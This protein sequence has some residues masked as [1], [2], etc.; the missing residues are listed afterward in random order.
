MMAD[1]QGKIDLI[2]NHSIEEPNES[3]NHF[4]LNLPFNF[5]F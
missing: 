1:L 4:Y 2:K 3:N 5:F